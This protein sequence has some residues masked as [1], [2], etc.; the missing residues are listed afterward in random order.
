MVIARLN[1]GKKREGTSAFSRIARPSYN[2]EAFVDIKSAILYGNKALAVAHLIVKAVRDEHRLR[3]RK[4]QIRTKSF[5]LNFLLGCTNEELEDFELARL[6]EI[7]NL[8][9]E[10]QGLMDPVMEP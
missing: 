1:E 3:T 5:S 2:R 6:G 8:R 9:T 4:A 10:I 7:A